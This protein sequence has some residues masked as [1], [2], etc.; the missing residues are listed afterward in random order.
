MLHMLMGA[1]CRIALRKTTQSL[2][3]T[4]S[5][6]TFQQRTFCMLTRPSIMRPA[7]PRMSLM[8]SPFQKQFGGISSVYNNATAARSFSV[9]LKKRPRCVKVNKYKLKTKKAAA[10]RMTVVSNRLLFSVSCV[11]WYVERPRVQ[12]PLAGSLALEP[13]QELAKQTQLSH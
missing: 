4:T 1:S 2:I 5:P 6:F 9:V 8:L 3:K 10:K 11:D 12:V 7:M 13:E